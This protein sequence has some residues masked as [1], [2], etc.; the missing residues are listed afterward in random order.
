MIRLGRSS[1][2]EIVPH[3]DEFNHL[4]YA[5]K[6]MVE[7]SIMNLRF[8]VSDEILDLK[9]GSTWR[10]ADLV[11]F[12]VLYC[13]ACI[14]LVTVLLRMLMAML[15]VTFNKVRRPGSGGGVG[16]GPGS[17]R[18]RVRIRLSTNPAVHCEPSLRPGAHRG[19]AR[20]AH[21]LR[22]ERAP[23][24]DPTRRLEGRS[25]DRHLCRS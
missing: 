18:V 3:V 14:L 24:R 12:A 6:A 4:G 2:N 15:T 8:D 13:Y 11:V 10:E 21:P 19:D 20:V 9:L 16:F 17:P 7:L 5:F 22:A 25:F 23:R 1:G